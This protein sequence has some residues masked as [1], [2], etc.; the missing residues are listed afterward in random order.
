MP[1]A[2]GAGGAGFADDGV[3]VLV[4]DVLVLAFSLPA[5]NKIS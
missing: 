5:K 1:L 4:L 2:T 3:V